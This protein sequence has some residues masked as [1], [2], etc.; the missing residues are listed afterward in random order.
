MKT[1]SITSIFIVAVTVAFFFLR[2]LDNRL[3]CILIYGMA[4]TSSYELTKAYGEKFSIVNKWVVLSFT[5]LVFPIAV[6]L[7]EKLIELYVLLFFIAITTVALLDKTKK[8]NDLA[9]T[10]LALVYPTI[11]L[12]SLV[13]INSA[14]NNVSLFLLVLTFGITYLTDVGAYL[15]GSL[16][17]GPKLCPSISPNKTISGAVG[18]TVLG[19]IVSVA[20]YFIFSAFG[21][22]LFQGAKTFSI[23]LFL[24][25]S[26]ILFSVATQIGDLFESVLKRKLGVKDM[27][28]FMPGHGGM[29][30]RIDG[31]S[32]T[33]LIIFTVYSF[34]L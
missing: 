34:L 2:E 26:G 33:S 7:V 30:D 25:M 27:G 4:L 16:V 5:A 31:L 13:L 21:V 19:V 8:L 32:F 14:S 10:A 22:V 20:T 3:F 11:P 28:K 9:Y 6:F 17:K 1:R 18:G 15:V 12:L 29:L 23:V 24:I